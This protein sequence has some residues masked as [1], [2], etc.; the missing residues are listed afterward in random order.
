MDG[1]LDDGPVEAQ[2][3]ALCHLELV[4]QPDEMS[5][6][7]VERGGLNAHGTPVQGVVV[8]HRRDVHATA[9]A[10]YQTIADE[11]CGLRGGTAVIRRMRIPFAQVSFNGLKEDIVVEQ[12]VHMGK[13]RLD[14]PPQRGNGHKEVHRRIAIPQHKEPRRARK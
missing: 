13:D 6:Q 12:R 8:R 14:L 3:T 9:L 10:Q 2:F 7:A 5:Q 4:G 1:G 11:L